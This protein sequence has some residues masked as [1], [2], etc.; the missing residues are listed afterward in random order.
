MGLLSRTLETT[1]RCNALSTRIEE[2]ISALRRERNEKL[3]SDIEIHIPVK[4]V[5]ELKRRGLW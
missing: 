4:T 1:Y 3:L 5:E 2:T